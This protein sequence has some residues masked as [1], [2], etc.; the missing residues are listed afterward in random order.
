M[1]LADVFSKIITPD[2]RVSFRAYDGSSVG[3]QD[4]DVILEIRSPRAVQF[5]AGAPSQLGLARAYVSGDLEIIGDAYTALKRLYPLDT[6][7]LSWRDKLDLAKAFGTH[8]LK[9]PTPPPQ[10]RRLRGRRHSKG[11]DAEAI[12]HHYDVSN[13]FYRWVLGPSMAYT[14]AVF[15]DADASLEA[16]QEEKFDLVCRKLGLRPGMRL[17]DVGCGWGGMVLH[18]VKNYGV[19]A[20]GVTLSAQQA[21]WGQEA[22]ADAGLEGQAQIRFSDY[23]DVPESEFDAVSSIGLTEHIGR[24]N[25]PSYF[26]F[27]Y[28]KIREEGRMLNHTITRPNNDEPSHYRTSFINRYV[29]PDGELSGPGYIMSAMN[30]AGFEIR[31]EENLREHYALTLKHWCE[32]L[33]DHWDE[34]VAEAGLGIARVWRLYLAASRLGFDLDT[35]QLHQTLGVKLGPGGSSGMP[36]LPDF[37]RAASLA[38]AGI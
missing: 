29:F 12:H 19:S 13:R 35:I 17:L 23:R 26:S 11:R 7:H 3:P 21:Q 1:K 31:H 2:R 22:I 5:L 15:P 32:N 30:D 28:G 27:L 14:C 8:A 6:S 20:I 10:E 34:S 38:G 33:E 24:A 25:Y 16:A 37:T 36:L 4:N 9:R 18:A